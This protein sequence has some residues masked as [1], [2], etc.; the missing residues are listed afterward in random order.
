MKIAISMCCLHDFFVR[1]ELDSL[2]F[3]KY[4]A[5]L[6]VDGVEL[7]DCYLQNPTVV[8]ELKQCL[9][10]SNLKVASYAV[11]L[12]PYD[13]ARLKNEIKMAAN[14]GA[15][16]MRLTQPIEGLKELIPYLE[17][18]EMTLCVDGDKLPLDWKNPR[19]KSSFEM[20]ESFLRGNKPDNRVG[21]VR[22][23]DVRFASGEGRDCIGSVL[24]L[25]LVEVASLLKDL[26]ELNYS[27]WIIV[28]YSGAE[29]PLFGLEASLKNL[30]QHLREL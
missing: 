28:D 30:R 27:G 15:D 19:I 18:L 8:D 5:S 12:E 9:A 24:G 26:C 2:S 16:I 25:G 23:N 3:I 1:K 6:V 17:K 14:L 11:T 20:A 10:E 21:L 22:A 29:D 7:C 13:L 4:A